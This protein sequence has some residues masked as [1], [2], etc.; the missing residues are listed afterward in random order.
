MIVEP[1]SAISVAGLLER[2]AAGEIPKGCTVVL[3]VTGH[4]L[5]DPQWALRAADG[6]EVTPTVVPVDV[7]EIAGLLG[8]AR[9]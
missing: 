4:G 6:S 2:S 5:K 8:L 9:A 1:A 3:T 7:A